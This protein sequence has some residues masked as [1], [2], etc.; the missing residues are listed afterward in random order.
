MRNFLAVTAAFLALSGLLLAETDPEVV[1]R[2]SRQGNL[3]RVV[4]QAEE[5]VIGS[6][7]ATLSL[8]S[9]RLLFPSRLILRMPQDFPFDVVQKDRLLTVTLK[10]V[11]DIRS[12]KL[13]DPARLVIELK[14]KGADTAQ[15]PGQKQDVGQKS[16]KDEAPQAQKPLPPV[17]QTDQQATGAEPVPAPAKIP[18]VV[19]DAGH[20]GYE[21]GIFT[22]EA[23]E[24]DISLTLAKDLG[25]ALQ[26]KGFR[27]FLTRKVDQSVPIGERILFA[28]GKT[29]DLFLSIHATA[30]ETFLIYTSTADESVVDA[31]IKLYRLSSRQNRHLEKSRNVANAVVEAIK[32]D[33]KTEIVFRELPLPVLS[34]MDA[35]AILLEYP[36]TEK[37]SYNQKTRDRLVNA[38]I[39]GISAY[40]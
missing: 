18:T 6:T 38:V 39:R 1:L 30:S 16:P 31:A 23:K 21:Y 5:N 34:S 22:Q 3:I 17:Q 11:T 2:F 8:S 13:S 12:Y 9:I 27:T 20:G 7:N 4:L 15:E 36:M 26:K 24:K 28:N 35:P 37:Y 29:P 10:D 14:T 33:F 25:A 40:E 19:I 32:S